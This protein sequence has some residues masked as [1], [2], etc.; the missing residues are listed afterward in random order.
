M[1]H[2]V[3][4]NGHVCL[5]HVPR[6]SSADSE[7][8]RYW[9][10]DLIQQGRNYTGLPPIAS[11]FPAVLQCYTTKYSVESEPF[12]PDWDKQ[13]IPMCK[14]VIAA[15]DGLFVRAKVV[16]GTQYLGTY[17]GC[18]EGREQFLT[19][20]VGSYCNSASKLAE[21]A[22]AKPQATHYVYTSASQHCSTYL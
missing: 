6:R 18:Q 19:S 17:V 13:S 8:Q 21:Y 22:E 1:C 12:A 20:K 5:Q 3:A 4:F 14:R 10:R 11:F 16:P 7:G 9:L 2:T 15:Y